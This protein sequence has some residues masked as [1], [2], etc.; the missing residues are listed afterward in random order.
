MGEIGKKSLE[1]VN[2][3]DENNW[4]FQKG[5]LTADANWHDLDLSSIVDPE[6]KLIHLRAVIQYSVAAGKV[7]SFRKN[8]SS[9]YRNVLY[10]YTQNTSQYIALDGLVECDSN[11]V[12]EYQVSNVVWD[13]LSIYV[14]GWFK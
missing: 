8:G 7:V 10:Q 11:N 13:F 5:D 12:I 6:A 14:R 3:G 2:R 1:Y 9:S 4:D